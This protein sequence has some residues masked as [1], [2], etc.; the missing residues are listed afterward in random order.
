MEN[1]KDGQQPLQEAGQKAP[2]KRLTHREKR[3][4]WKAAKKAKR[5]E[6]KEFYR[7]APALKRWW[8]LYLWKPT[9]VILALLVLFGA[10][11]EPV[12][13]LIDAAVMINYHET[14]D[15]PLSEADIPKLYEQ[16]PLDE[17]GAKRIDAIPAVGEDE[18]WAIY[19]Y[20]VGSN[21][22][23]CDENDLS[24]VT[25]MLSRDI[26]DENASSKSSQRSENLSRFNSE[27]KENG[28]D[29]P[30][31]FFYPEK[32]VAS[33][34]VVTNDVIVADS[35]GAASADIAEMTAGTW[36]DNISIVI[37]TGG[38]TRWSN[39]M[40]NPN[41][42]QRFLYHGGDFREVSN[43]SLE[44]PSQPDTLAEF[45][46]FCKKEYP[47]D[48]T[49]LVFWNHG[50]GPFGYGNDSIFS[51]A[52]SLADIRQALSDVYTP[53]RNKPAF[54]IIGFDACLMSCL[55]VTHTLDG[56]ARYYCLSEE[57]EPG[58][59][60]D[61]TPFLQAMSDDPTMSPAK[62]AQHVADSYTD[63]YMREN[64]NQDLI[65]MDVTFS[66]IDA[67]KA[68]ELYDAYA[69][70]CQAQL[71]DAYSDMGV[72]AEIGRCASRATRYAGSNSNVFNTIDLG[73]YMDYLSDSYPDE[74]ARVK[75]LIGEAV[76]Y[77]RE[78]GGVSDST[79]IAVY[80]P[81]DI[82]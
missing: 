36:S 42:T 12:Q 73:N 30:D 31:F 82:R 58:D 40:V 39:Q 66:V 8:M 11:A 52:F 75:E 43:L 57:V 64:I 29:L 33:S 60:W 68:A 16:S 18:T 5:D 32:P 23:D 78:N 41:R 49:M 13:K 1:P 22:E 77:H 46:R 65:K 26:R 15:L 67:P 2:S 51:G 19:V 63:Y 9:A 76:L 14:K 53:N 54:D 74:C 3:Q 37:Q 72:L 10:L 28:L 79:G 56:F 48:H 24:Y 21:L 70:L 47:A 27:L 17:E 59:G 62:V 35:L 34:E 61:Y 4:L 50:G 25:S 44:P 55:E 81:G 69:A 7:Y 80:V 45:L 6:L 20:M 38:A 71:L